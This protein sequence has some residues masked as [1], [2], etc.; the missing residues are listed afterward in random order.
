M[1]QK[2]LFGT[3]LFLLFAMSGQMAFGEVGSP[4]PE[5]SVTGTSTDQRPRKDDVADMI[6]L[7][8]NY[9]QS[10]HPT[11]E[12]YFWN[13]AVYHIGNMEAY[14]TTGETAYL[15]FS[16][17]WSESNNWS[18]PAG[19]DPSQ[20]KYSYGENNVLFGDCQVCFQ[21]YSEL[22]DVKPEEKRI[23]RAKQVLEYQIGTSQND[24]LYWVDGLFMVMPAM[25]HLYTITKDERYLE[26]MHEYWTYANSIMYDEE[27]GLY[28][29]DAKYVYPGHSTL[30]GK[31]DFWA[32]GDGWIFA[33]FARVL[34]DLPQEHAH[35]GEYIAYYQ[36]M[37]QALAACQQQEGH[38][39]RSLL[40][41]EYAPGYETSGTALILYGYLWGVNHG[42]LSED[43]YAAVI[44][45]AWTYLS[46]I[47][48]QDRGL[49][50]YIQPI[51]EKADP[52]Q[53]VGV[54]STAD[55]GVGA[56]LMAASEM[57]RY[58]VEDPT[59]RPLRLMRAE[60]LSDTEILL[61]FNEEVDEQT[62][63]ASGQY[64]LDGE[65]ADAAVEVNG[66]N[67]ILS[68]SAPLPYG[69]PVLTI[70]GLSSM[71][72]EPMEQAATRTLFRPVP[73]YPNQ[74]IK[75]VTSSGSQAGNP[76]S[77][78][79]DNDL[80]TRW[81][82]AGIGEW[83]CF[84]LGTEIN[85]SAIDLSFY[86][87]AQR[88][89]YFSIQASTDGTEFHTVL[90]N[91]ETSGQT[92]ELER[93][94]LGTVKARYIRIVCQGNSTGG[95]QWNSITEA[96][97]VSED[98]PFQAS[99]EGSEVTPEGAWC[100]FADPRALHHESATVNATYI[101]YIDVHGSIKAMQYDFMKNE[102]K[103]VLIRSYFQPDDH[104]NPTFLVLP[105]ERIMVFYSRHTDEPCFYYRISK[106]KGDITTLGEEKIIP[107]KDNTTYPSPF[108]LSE[109]PTHFYIC[110]RG[111]NWH[112]TIARLTLPDHEDNV[113][114]DWGPYQIVQSTGARPYAKYDSNGKDK[115]MLA[116][117]TGH[118]DNEYPN[119]VYFNAINIRTLQLED[120]NGNVLSKIQ[121]G[122]FKVTKAADYAA[123]YPA[124]IVDKPS[125]KRDWLWQVAHN[126]DGKPAIAMVQINQDKSSHD[127]YYAEWDGTAWKKTFLIN[128]GG[129]FHQTP[130][131]E[132]CYSAGMAMN[133]ANP[134]EVYVSAPVEG[135]NGKVYE[136][137]KMT[138][139][140]D[141]TLQKESLTR[142]SHYNNVRPYFIPGT[143]NS[144]LKLAWMH[145]KYYDWIVSSS[146][147]EG[148]PTAIHCDYEWP[149]QTIDLNEGLI[150]HETFDDSAEGEPYN[151]YS[152]AIVKEGILLTGNEQ[153]ASIPL[154]NTDFTLSLSL[155]ISHNQYQG[156]I[157]SF[158]NL[159]YG[160]DS[161]TLKPYIRIGEYRYDSSSKLAT[162]DI[163]REQSRGTGGVWYTPSKLDFFNLT[164]VYADGILTSYINGLADQQLEV[165]GFLPSDSLHIGGFRG[166]VEDFHLY[167]R[168]LHQDEVKQLSAV[169]RQYV[170]PEEL[171]A[172]EA[173]ENIRVPQHIY[174]DIPLTTK[175]A[176]G[177]TVK[178]TSSNSSI[179]SSAGIV[180]LP[181]T[182]EEVVLTA[183]IGSLQRNFTTTVHPRDLSN[184]LLLHYTFEAPDVYSRDGK[185]F[186]ADQS[187]H[188]RD[189]EI[190]GSALINGTL[191]LTK[192]TAA[193]F[194]SNG[195]L[196]A[197][198]GILEHLR[199]YTFFLRVLPKNLNSAPRLYDFGSGSGNSV[200]GRGNAFTAGIKYNGG[201]TAMVNASRQLPVGRET[202]VAF[203]YN[204]AT[205]TTS[206]Y[207]NGVLVGSGTNIVREAFEVAAIG[208]DRRN[209]IGRTQWWDSSVAS[210]NIDYC[211][212][213][214]NFYVFDIALTKDEI[215][216][217]C[218]NITGVEEI[219]DDA[220]SDWSWKLS[221]NVCS[222]RSPLSVLSNESCA[223]FTLS[224]FSSSGQLVN[225]LSHLSAYSKFEAPA[226]R[227][228][229]LVRISNSSESTKTEKLVVE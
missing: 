12:N 177:Q 209:Y 91:G 32:R 73:L 197:P 86:Q 59:P 51:G 94:N 71:Q 173:L 162:S 15:D 69:R 104:D 156:E 11:H 97:I 42:I 150:I 55:F 31:K 210:S 66:K 48:L 151:E 200:F 189:A 88:N 52:N 14:R 28:F 221:H 179:L 60:I 176:S 33:A 53:T 27:T 224:I 108:I 57:Y 8:N 84:D 212:E 62:A 153:Y 10:T 184:N 223:D 164:L 134:R 50:G 61:S 125:D 145:G 107:T 118:P 175:T 227:G 24:Y 206:I 83:I 203:T 218:Q 26:K 74:Y 106:K 174:S 159:Q 186:L 126:E 207:M 228:V 75:S 147:P 192:N 6:H 129:H 45:Q 92:D 113:E 39:T 111:I 9:W 213:M 34:A 19:D 128:G 138:V 216:R 1:M 18:G 54:N 168:P 201:T 100:W 49:V 65:A 96:R 98:P 170:L 95:D 199:S 180:H 205:R 135:L 137:L 47:A 208:E 171:K 222:P 194:S 21:V 157:L 219:Q 79:I 77:N 110:W 119:Y 160:L 141:G 178:W 58:A 16:T 38:W 36:K 190:A 56:Y 211:G 132:K 152:S 143:E 35:R 130:N 122:P 76:D 163:W 196:I 64:M 112:P 187:G 220:R 139:G 4:L 120:V 121:N 82:Q 133:P 166:W 149:A 93:Y 2:K 7:V 43:D 23:A 114:I 193:G 169:S 115:I 30:S 109:D 182:P 191:D 217:L 123:K 188:G 116:Y 131:L 127:Y 29:R 146:H 87:G 183:N 148:Y 68:F 172:E 167:S 198:K 20:W 70:S 214:D 161:L 90:E 165:A 99:Y 225:H 46:T 63:Q 80:S 81:S 85:V 41:P 72:G 102:R 40:D 101:G 158:G 204:A 5:S 144:P 89:S 22:Y 13:R 25:S 17:A 117:T 142:N 226:E 67:V 155:Q 103:E 195:Y 78:T 3:F 215:D 181:E 154:S 37:A 105:D 44:Q 229:Y 124:T 202:F 185:K 136:I 140:S